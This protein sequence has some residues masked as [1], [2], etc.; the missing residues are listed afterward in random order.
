MNIAIGRS[1]F[2]LAAI[3]SFYSSSKDNY[4]GHEIRADFI[5]DSSESKEHYAKLLK[6][7]A[8]IE[9]KMNES[10]TWYNPDNARVCKIS[11]IKPTDLNNRAKWKDDQIWLLDKLEK[12]HTVFQPLIKIL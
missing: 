10:L 9:S 3:A 5:I 11:L 6:Q 2:K 7:K 8:E 1:G 4:S 12:L